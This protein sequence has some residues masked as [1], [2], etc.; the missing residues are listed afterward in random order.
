MERI[1]LYPS[2]NLKEL[3]VKEAEKKDISLSQLAVDILLEHY[4]LNISEN[5]KLPLS[6]VV[7]KILN[8]VERYVKRNPVG[9]GFDLL[10]ASKTFRDI[11]MVAEGKASTN[12]ATVGKIFASRL[13]AEPFA[14]VV[15]V[16]TE[17]GAV[18][19]SENKATL[20]E[21]VSE[22]TFKEKPV[23]K[24]STATSKK[25][26]KKKTVKLT[27]KTKKV[28]ETPVEQAPEVKPQPARQENFTLWW[29]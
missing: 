21:I 29:D 23:R 6:E 18:K 19:K 16:R 27:E 24:K 9:T 15:V 22:K 13:G 1:Q 28:V 25:A 2:E 5:E 10:K 20:Y 14:N 4:G 12:R 17:S 3:M 7:E 11:H 26:T 8:E